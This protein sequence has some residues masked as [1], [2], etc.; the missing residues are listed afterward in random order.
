MAILQR[1]TTQQTTKKMINLTGKQNAVGEMYSQIL[2][3]PIVGDLMTAAAAGASK[4]DDNFTVVAPV[5]FC[6]T[7]TI[8]LYIIVDNPATEEDI[9]TADYKHNSSVYDMR[10]NEALEITEETIQQLLLTFPD[11]DFTPY[12]GEYMIGFAKQGDIAV[13]DTYKFRVNGNDAGTY[14]AACQPTGES[15]PTG[16]P[17]GET[18]EPTG[19][20]GGTGEPTGETGE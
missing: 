6:P 17:T 9:P 14:T 20:T 1:I 18:G 15:E 13:G 2:G 11:F 12:I 3:M 8:Y 7:S 4:G 19:E 16:E 5:F 10:L